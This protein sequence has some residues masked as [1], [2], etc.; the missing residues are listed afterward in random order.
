[1]RILTTLTYY[2]P[3]I[4]GLTVYARRLVRRLVQRGHSVTVL[5]SH[6]G[7]ELSWRENLDGATIVRSPVLALVSK[8]A[9]MPLFLWDAARL[10]GSHDV[11]YL[12]LPQIEAS[13]VALLAKALRKPVVTTYHCDIELPP[14]AIR[15]LT[16]PAIRLSHY[17]TGKLSDRIVVNTDE[18]GRSARLPRRFYYK[19]LSVYPPAE[20]AAEPTGGFRAHHGLGDGPLVG[21]VGR[22]A[23]EKGIAYLIDSVP[24]VLSQIPDVRYVLAGPTEMVPGERVHEKIRP[25]MEALGS[26]LIHVGLLSDAELAEFYRTVDVLVLPSTNSTESFGMT[27]VE[28]MLSGTPVV[29]TDI[30]GVREPVRVTGMGKLVPPCDEQA[31]ARAIVAVLRDRRR[32]LRPPEEIRA[33]FDPEKTVAFY[34]ELFAQLLRHQPAA[35]SDQEETV[36]GR[37]SENPPGGPAHEE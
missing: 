25:K 33:Q 14:G 6:F 11:V 22:F 23:E 21:F 34:E 27:Q 9:V 31:L 10:I 32:Y 15:A 13:G 16:T 30:P 28:A 20:L 7:H 29:A 2:T 24:L 37:P 26:S 36:V 8:G 18:Y 19:V 1:M 3:H 17:L 35:L 12:H 5:T 4:S